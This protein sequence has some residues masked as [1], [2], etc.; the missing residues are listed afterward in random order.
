MILTSKHTFGALRVLASPTGRG[1]LP[2]DAGLGAGPARRRGGRLAAR[3]ALLGGPPDGPD[4][5][6]AALLRLNES[7]KIFKILHLLL[8]FTFRCILYILVKMI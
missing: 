2:G 7:D 3:L 5:G 8:F 6:R 1:L 4:G